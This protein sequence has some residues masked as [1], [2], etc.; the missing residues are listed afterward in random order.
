MT[1]FVMVWWVVH[2]FWML[3]LV[4]WRIEI[5]VVHPVGDSPAFAL[6]ID[7]SPTLLDGFIVVVHVNGIRHIIL[8]RVNLNAWP[9]GEHSVDGLR[10]TKSVGQILWFHILRLFALPFGG[11]LK[12][13]LEKLSAPLRMLLCVGEGGCQRFES[14]TSF[15]AGIRVVAAINWVPAFLYFLPQLLHTEAADLNYLFFVYLQ[16]FRLIGNITIQT[17]ANLCDEFTCTCVAKSVEDEHDDTKED[18][19]D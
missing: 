3:W 12:S 9:F 7:M 15:I 8:R 11:L 5:R 18:V 2:M 17:Q 19:G 4:G 1:V 14:V 10:L 16:L 6:C 13:A